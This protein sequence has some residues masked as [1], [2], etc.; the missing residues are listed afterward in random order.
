[1]RLA[2]ILRRPVIFMAGLYRGDNRYHVVFAPIA[3]FSNTPAGERDAAVAQA[4]E[5]YAAL[6]DRYCRKRSLQLVQFLRFLA[7]ARQPLRRRESP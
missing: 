3:D 7:R 5:R 2:A 1:M 6:L 4:I